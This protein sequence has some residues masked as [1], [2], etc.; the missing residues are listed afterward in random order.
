[1]PPRLGI[2]IIGA[3]RVGAVLGAALRAEGHAI[4]GVYAV[5]DV[6]RHRA[7]DLLPGVPVLGVQEIV[8]RSE[9]VLLAV[10]DDQ[11]GPLAEGIAV[12]VDVPGGQLF[13]HVSGRHG[14]EV[15]A[16]LRALGCGVIALHPAMS[17]TGT[18]VDL[19]RL[20]GCP[21]AVTAHGTLEAVAQ[22]LVV[23]IGAE[24]VP[25]AEGDRVQYHAAL[26]HGANHLVV[27]VSQARDLLRGIGI[28]D[29]GAYLRPLLTAALEESLRRGDAALTGPVPR[30]D[31]G[32]VAAHLAA[33]EEA[34]GA[35]D[36][37]AESYRALARA[38]V[39]R[40]GLSPTDARRVLAALEPASAPRTTPH[41]SQGSG[42][43][44]AATDASD[45]PHHEEHA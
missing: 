2:G 25:I 44:P 13:V 6:S 30:G 20:V 29:P 45:H 3:G 1:M 28:E 8:E 5:S 26:A 42:A 43:S 36:D 12:G 23:E 18:A 31:A 21:V 9:V 27:L 32:T 39:R 4:T 37:T 41:A 19:P 15:L 14:T 35:S 24:P 34:E 33:I 40:A 11:L 17:F 22:A 38:A 16:P 10:P 7:A